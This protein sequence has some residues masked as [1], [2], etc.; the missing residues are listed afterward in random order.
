MTLDLT[1]EDRYILEGRYGPGTAMAMSIITRMAEVSGAAGLID[2]SAAHIDSALFMGDATL[3]FAERLVEL[4]AKVQV[5]TSLN[6]SGLDEA[7]WR[8]WP[9]PEIYAEKALRQMAAY[10]RMG[11]APTWTCAPYQ[12][13]FRPQ[14]GQQIAWG[15]S[16]AIAFVNSVVGART[17]RYPDLLD[18]CAAITGRVPATGLHLLE[19]RRGQILLRLEHVPRSMQDSSIFYPVLGTIMGR[20]AGERVPV[21]DGLNI[22]PNED[23]LKALG[24]AAASAGGV[25][26]YHLVGITPEAPSLQVAFQGHLP[27]QEVEINLDLLVTTYRGLSSTS[28][29]RLDMVAVGCPHFSLAEF[30]QL[31]SIIKGKRRHPTVQ[32][33]VTTNRFML[34]KA[35]EAGYLDA[36]HEFG[37]RVSLDACILTSPMLLPEIQVILTNSGKYTYY[38]PGLLNRQVFL[39]S[40]EECVDSAVEGRLVR[41]DSVWNR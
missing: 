13:E 6:V 36:L 27:E 26:L 3:E 11:C 17:E 29:N 14:F 12:T 18:I 34:G 9:V 37:A 15:E 20:A 35:R 22:T 2:I 25:A 33:L 21:V 28:G 16:N 40:L 41:E 1:R 7:G 38:T 4:G 5:P 24:A 39:G 32:F 19:N 31:A 10:Q 8:E 23:Q 30:Q